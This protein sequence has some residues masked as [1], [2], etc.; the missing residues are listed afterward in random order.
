MMQNQFAGSTSN[1]EHLWSTPW[2]QTADVDTTSLPQEKSLQMVRVRRGLEDDPLY[3]HDHLQ[4]AISKASLSR[5]DLIHVV[6]QMHRSVSSLSRSLS[7]STDA[8]LSTMISRISSKNEIVQEHDRYRQ[9]L[10]QFIDSKIDQLNKRKQ[11]A[12]Q[13]SN[14]VRRDRKNEEGGKA[15]EYSALFDFYQNLQSLVRKS[16][17]ADDALLKQDSNRKKFNVP[18]T[19][20]SESDALTPRPT[21]NL[22]YQRKRAKVIFDEGFD[23]GYETFQDIAIPGY[24]SEMTAAELQ[25]LFA[26]KLLTGAEYGALEHRIVTKGKQENVGAAF[27]VMDKMAEKM[28]NT[29][30]P[31]D[32]YGNWNMLPLPQSLYALAME[33][34]GRCLPL[35]LL[36]AT[37][38]SRGTEAV[39]NFS[40]KVNGALADPRSQDAMLLKESLRSMH[41]VPLDG[42][43][44]DIANLPEFNIKD[45]KDL[46]KV[47][48]LG[49]EIYIEDKSVVVFSL[50]EIVDLIKNAD[51][52][53]LF[54]VNTATH[55]MLV[56]VTFPVE[57]NV[58]SN[59]LSVSK[60]ERVVSFFDPNTGLLTLDSAAD[61][62]IAIEYYLKYLGLAEKYKAYGKSGKPRFRVKRI[63]PKAAGQ[64]TLANQLKV[65]DFSRRSTLSETIQARRETEQLSNQLI[66]PE[67]TRQSA[68][69]ESYLESQ[70]QARSYADAD[71]QIRDQQALQSEWLLPLSEIRLSED[72]MATRGRYEL[73]YVHKENGQQRKIY[74]NDSTFINFKDY[75]EN[76]LTGFHRRHNLNN[77]RAEFV[78][79]AEMEEQN[80]DGLSEAFL[81]QSLIEGFK[82]KQRDK[83]ADDTVASDLKNVLIVHGYLT[84]LQMAQG[85]AHDV[86]KTV[87]LFRELQT[88]GAAPVSVYG[89]A[90]GK[91][92]GGVGVVFNGVSIAADIYEL[93]HVENDIQKAI[94]TAQLVTDSTGLVINGAAIGASLLGAST[95]ATV[96][97]GVGVI[98]GGLSVGAFAL[99]QNYAVLAEEAKELAICFGKIKKAYA[100]DGSIYDV[101]KG[102]LSACS[103]V[104]I[105]VMDFKRKQLILGNAYLYASEY[106]LGYVYY[107]SVIKDKC[108]AINLRTNYGG[109]EA[110]NFVKPANLIATIL[111]SQPTYYL[112]LNQYV[113][114]LSVLRDSGPEFEAIDE[115]ERKNPETVKFQ[116][117]FFP[118]KRTVSQILCEYDT[119]NVDIILD[120]D[121]HYLV[122]PDL[123]I[124]QHGYLSY[125]IKNGGGRVVADLNEGVAFSL[126][127][128]DGVPC[129]NFMLRTNQL[130]CDVIEIF[131]DRL[132]VGG[133]NISVDL[134]VRDYVFV[135]N[136]RGEIYKID[137]VNKKTI[138][139]SIDVQQ[140]Q[141][142]ADT[143]QQT[144]TEHLGALVIEQG[145]SAEYIQVNNY[146][147]EQRNVGDAYYDVK[148]KR[149]LFS[150]FGNTS[151][152]A[153]E[154]A[155][156][157]FEEAKSA[158]VLEMTRTSTEISTLGFGGNVGDVSGRDVKRSFSSTQ[159][160]KLEEWLA[161][162]RQIGLPNSAI[163]A[164]NTLIVQIKKNLSVWSKALPTD[165]GFYVPKETWETLSA[166]QKKMFSSEDEDQKKKVVT[167]DKLSAQIPADKNYIA[168]EIRQSF[169][170][171]NSEI[172]VLD[173][174]L[175]TLTLIAGLGHGAELGG[176][177]AMSF[178]FIIVRKILF[179]ALM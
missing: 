158:N 119:T 124:Q 29:L 133:I 160:T 103:G 25:E 155:K 45:P 123:P 82:A 120:S 52:E 93:A 20:T 23:R 2:I 143:T 35:T 56:G 33:D 61:L 51:K 76:V 12:L 55:S 139:S 165:S 130:K 47:I 106:P 113:M 100:A 4:N 11:Q 175:A 21:A 24:V 89:S 154:K 77:E 68:Q 49:E 17:Q 173:G 153:I 66:H 85:V 179:G 37:A 162:W 81:L 146:V 75:T 142:F 5:Q 150:L 92:S 110:V 74:T 58:L 43:W 169:V 87:S 31:M 91:V 134:A 168:N 9:E 14:T 59:G 78:P 19:S 111:P 22:D 6:Q 48:A 79:N 16:K 18:L 141:K 118:Y 88:G 72:Q 54:A 136:Q 164:L 80:V 167:L 90:L 46:S 71:A 86:V 1:S 101:S 135:S 127:L 117:K 32:G 41:G 36:M 148:N 170:K 131:E 105:K 28:R 121:D 102:I 62:H 157:F 63:D 15:K 114:V 115:L 149:M 172:A 108:A 64:I 60:R 84:Q 53:T 151:S 137:F 34:Q 13:R 44:E 3:N 174:R 144:I 39:V 7:R 98:V 57:T 140:W 26:N 128:Q 126:S 42:V 171:L 83:T 122:A 70:Q 69:A 40:D 161:Y 94:F 129:G 95:A 152:A 177:L 112:S 99:A 178:I 30:V 8:S 96:L 132:K 145:L 27:A 38:L 73:N 116:H 10:N 159:L 104:V 166:Q 156:A 147:D 109:A 107:P 50:T 67:I 65:A 97:G 138:V 125:H 163:Q 176:W